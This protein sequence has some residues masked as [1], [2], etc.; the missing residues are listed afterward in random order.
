MAASSP[1]PKE[2]KLDAPLHEVGFEI[3]EI[4]PQKITGHF[5]VTDKCCNPFQV[6]HGGVSALIAESLASMGAHVACGFGRVAGIHL[7]I[8]HLKSANLGE[9]VFAE[10]APIN[11]GK[12][13]HVWEVKLWKNDPSKFGNKILISSSR[14]TL[15]TNMPVPENVKDAGVNLQKYA[16]L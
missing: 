2:E 10:A 6:L 11:V 5:L 16:R 3:S 7:S 4:S 8:H 1:V 14:V 12:T 15:K 13:I 9:I